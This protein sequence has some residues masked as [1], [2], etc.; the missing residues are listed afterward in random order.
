[1]TWPGWSAG[2]ISLCLTGLKVFPAS[3]FKSSLTKYTMQQVF[4]E[5]TGAEKWV[6][7]KVV[8]DAHLVVPELDPEMEFPDQYL[9][10]YVSNLTRTTLDMSKPLWEMHIL[11]LKSSEAAA[12]AVL[13][14]HHSLGDGASLM[15]LVLACARKTSDP[16]SPP[17]VPER[18]LATWK[19]SGLVPVLGIL[20]AVIRLL[21]HTFLGILVFLA[22]AAFLKDT[23]TPLMGTEGVEHRPKRVVHRT[24]SLDDMKAVKN[25]TDSTI[26]DVLLGI[27]AAGLSRYLRRQYGKDKA[28]DNGKHS[29][30]ANIRLRA[31]VLVN[32]RPTPKIEA[33]SDLMEGAKTD[34]EWGNRLGYVV[35]PFVLNWTEDPLD[36]IR[37]AKEIA[38]KKKHSL[39]AAFTYWS[40][41]FIVKF[42]GIKAGAAICRRML[43]NT[44]L[45]FSNVA[46]P[47]EEVSFYGHPLV[48]LA[49]TV[50]GHP[51]AWST[52]SPELNL[53]AL[54]GTCIPTST[55]ACM[56]LYMYNLQALTIHFQSYMNKMKMV[57]AV[58]ENA[59]PDPHQLLDDVTD[60]LKIIKDAAEGKASL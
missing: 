21:W 3:G 27:T 11:N 42:F 59:I 13:R 16:N 48:Y 58:D 34:I 44:T 56:R 10:D 51:H 9:E 20:W 33:L 6:R 40:G 23:G 37:R 46:G 29:L 60:C 8:V 22:T 55:A 5:K 14:I 25:A 19:R 47:R 32:I 12:T 31:A 50:C 28:T 2:P 24:L 1:M 43:K 15:S 49:P 41:C 38:D 17:T 57:V 35:V 18:R 54:N 53:E 45:S 36:H 39:E 52:G 7:T 30:P 4:D 26:N